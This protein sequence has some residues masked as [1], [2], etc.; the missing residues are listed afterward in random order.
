MTTV[1]LKIAELRKEKGIGQQ[2]LADVLGVSFQSVSKWETGATMPDIT[3]LPGI[4]EFFDVSV[5][6]ILGLKPLHHQAYIP[7]NSD[8]RDNWNGK[9]DKLFKNRKY[10]W[11][12]DYLSFLVKDVWHADKPV[13][14]IELTCGEGYFGKQLLELLP[15]G[16]SYT[17]VDNEFF[18]DRARSNFAKTEFDADFIISDIYSLKTDKKYDI[19]VCQAGL[20]HMNRPMEVLRI[21][22]D[23][24]KKGGLVAC[25]DVNREFENDGLYIDDIGYDYLCTTFDFHKVWKKELECEGRDYAV[26]MRLP[27]Y[28]RRLGL[29]D[30]DVRMNDR[31]VY[32]NPDTQDYE[33][34]LRDFVE[35]HGW[36]KVF[37]TSGREETVE[38]FMSRGMSRAEVEAYISMQATIADYFKNTE[39]KKSFLKVQ[40]LLI[41]Y[42]RK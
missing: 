6:E 4:A 21:M 34:K 2:E 10:F 32:V 18:V 25:I 28:M 22:T 9:T 33:E 3:L 1:K 12:D 19:A 36:D 7:R 31:V 8:N 29:H 35:I 42:G 37:D 23:A 13:N 14:I 27:F 16:S 39:R 26:G 41:T 40:G 5:D 38:F 30:V 11:N 24:V 17:G 20:R 15:A